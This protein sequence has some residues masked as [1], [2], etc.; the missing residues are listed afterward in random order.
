LAVLTIAAELDGLGPGK[1][2]Q[3]EFSFF[4]YSSAEL[5][6]AI[7]RPDELT[8]TVFAPIA[9][10]SHMPPADAPSKKCFSRHFGP[11]PRI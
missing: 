6:A 8:A 4:R 1:N 2:S 9:S 5:C 11:G 3:P 10:Q 7:L